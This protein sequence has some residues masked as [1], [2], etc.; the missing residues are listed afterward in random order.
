MKDIQNNFWDNVDDVLLEDFRRQ[1]AMA[2]FKK[3]LIRKKVM[4]N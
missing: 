1:K 2:K 3:Q 4:Y